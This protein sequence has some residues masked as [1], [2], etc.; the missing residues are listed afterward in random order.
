MSAGQ[1]PSY[2]ASNG[3]AILLFFL[4]FHSPSRIER[5]HAAITQ[6]SRRCAKEIER[7]VFFSLLFGRISGEEKRQQIK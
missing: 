5:T 6:L 3:N 2:R 4:I 7:P 1:G